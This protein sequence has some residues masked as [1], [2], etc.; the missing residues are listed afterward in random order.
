[1]IDKWSSSMIAA[2]LL[3]ATNT[4]KQLL[5]Q[6]QE[7]ENDSQTPINEKLSRIKKIR[8]EIAKVGMEVDNLKKELMLSN[9]YRIN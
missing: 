7:V 5:L 6:I 3:V 2:K 9:T 1:M 4:V 8:E